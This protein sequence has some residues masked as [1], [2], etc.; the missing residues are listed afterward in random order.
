MQ[1]HA[2]FNRLDMNRR[3]QFCIS[4]L[5]YSRAVFAIWFSSF[6]HPPYS[7]CSVSTRN[8]VPDISHVPFFLFVPICQICC[9]SSFVLFELHSTFWNSII[10]LPVLWLMDFVCC[11]WLFACIGRFV[12]PLSAFLLCHIEIVSAF[13]S[14]VPK[15]IN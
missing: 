1:R 15:W 13:I 9:G 6:F 10:S 5:E 12:N 14:S 11:F 2:I 8:S 3:L 7:F 4:K